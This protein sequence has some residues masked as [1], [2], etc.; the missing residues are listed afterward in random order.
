MRHWPLTPLLTDTGVALLG[1]KGNLQHC[2]P[3]RRSLL[4]FTGHCPVF[5]GRV[6]ICVLLAF[7][8]DHK[9]FCNRVQALE[10]TPWQLKTVAAIELS[11]AVSVSLFALGRVWRRIH[12]LLS[13]TACFPSST[14]ITALLLLLSSAQ[15][16]QC[17]QERLTRQAPNTCSIV[18]GFPDSPKESIDQEVFPT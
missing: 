15:Q 6:A 12:N 17:S 10:D 11:S 18:H 14:P 3:A 9:C 16:Q 1:G 13:S 4:P 7:A 2:A 5:A 8:Q